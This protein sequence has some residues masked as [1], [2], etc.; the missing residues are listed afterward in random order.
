MFL[1]GTKAATPTL[2][3]SQKVQEPTL[4]MSGEDVKIHSKRVESLQNTLE[5]SG[6][7]VLS[8]WCSPVGYSPRETL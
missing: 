5:T 8:S 7:D 6:E 1:P 3:S 4:E 2:F